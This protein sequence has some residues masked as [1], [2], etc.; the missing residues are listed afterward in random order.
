MMGFFKTILSVAVT[1]AVVPAVMA[2]EVKPTGQFQA[3]ISYY[4]TDV[5]DSTGWAL[6]MPDNFFG[7]TAVEQLANSVILG[8]VE[9]G[10]EPLADDALTPEVQQAYMGWNQSVFSLAAGRMKSLE[11]TYIVDYAGYLKG[12]DRG[13]LQAAAYIQ[14]FESEAVRLTTQAGQSLS[15]SGQMQMDPD[16]PEA[17]WSL[18]ALAS[19]TEGTVSVTY[20]NVP[21]E[22][23][24]WGMQMTW[25]SGTVSLSGAYMYQDEMLGYDIDLSMLSNGSEGFIGYSRSKDD[26]KRWQLGIHQNLA[27]TITSYSELLW[28]PDDSSW[29]WT[30]GFQ[31]TY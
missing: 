14:P 9:L 2:V 31:L 5:E 6:E 22:S 13:G 12:L 10:F 19:T 17:L 4:H 21:D 20:R 1:A 30:T 28:L 27:Q 3:Q 18:A 26:G 23:A 25:V 16:T 15:F 11:E 29:Q 7:I 24:L 8:T